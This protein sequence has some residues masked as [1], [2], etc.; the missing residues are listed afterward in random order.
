MNELINHLN[1]PIFSFQVFDIRGRK[2]NLDFQNV[3][4][5]HLN[6]LNK[7]CDEEVAAVITFG[8]GK[9]FSLLFVLSIF[10]N[11]LIIL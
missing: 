1:F 6:V 11:T 8:K 2:I 3:S 5:D 10:F 9:I 4:T 7:I